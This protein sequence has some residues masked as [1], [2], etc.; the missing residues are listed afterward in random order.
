MSELIS[1]LKEI[2]ILVFF[3]NNGPEITHFNFKKNYEIAQ[4]AQFP[5]PVNVLH[6]VALIL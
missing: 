5:F 1:L 4:E 6:Y 3:T 2:T